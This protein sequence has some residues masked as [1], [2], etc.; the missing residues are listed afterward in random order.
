MC[1]IFAFGQLCQEF[2]RLKCM[3]QVVQLKLLPYHLSFVADTVEQN[4]LS[5]RPMGFDALMT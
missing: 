2:A 4:D 3:Q 5:M 1:L